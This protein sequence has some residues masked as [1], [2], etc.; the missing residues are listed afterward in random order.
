MHMSP[1][2]SDYLLFFHRIEHLKKSLVITYKCSY[3]VIDKH[4][5]FLDEVN[6]QT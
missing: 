3:I 4:S 1:S 6:Y 2:S 5:I